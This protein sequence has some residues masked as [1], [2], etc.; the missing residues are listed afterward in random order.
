MK[1][2]LVL[3]A[4][5]AITAPAWAQSPRAAA[6]KPR[7][8]ASP[9]EVYEATREADVRQ[10]T[11]AIFY[12]LT[13]EAQ[14]IEVL[15]YL[16]ACG[17]TRHAEKA[18]TIRKQYGVD[19]AALNAEYDKRYSKKHGFD[20][21]GWRAKHDQAMNKALD[22]ANAPNVIELDTSDVPEPPPHDEV[23]VRQVVSDLVTDKPG[24][25]EAVSKLVGSSDQPGPGALV[26]LRIQGDNAVGRRSSTWYH[27][28]TLGGQEKKVW[29]TDL[30]T[31]R[32]RKVQ[33][34]WLIDTPE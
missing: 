2:V 29:T 24:F 18:Q 28:H 33:G 9:Q 30:V 32:F 15:E 19:E 8:Y 14:E 17:T 1:C 34:S 7:V 21:A 27:L 26:N 23:L 31:I 25:C 11:R 5:M 16:M 6:I 13:P 22:K 3:S 10:D 20:L 4:V 12:C